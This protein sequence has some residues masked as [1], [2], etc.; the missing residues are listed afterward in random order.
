[1]M[2]DLKALGTQLLSQN[3]AVRA[4]YDDLLKVA[5]KYR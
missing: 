3:P 1:M 2:A 5:D 4:E